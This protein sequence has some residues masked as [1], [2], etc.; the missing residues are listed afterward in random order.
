MPY[1]YHG[2]ILHV[3]LDN[4]SFSVETPPETFYRKYMGGSAFGAYYLLKNTPTNIDPYS[5]E[6]TLVLSVG[7]VTGA[8]ISG[9]S[10][11]TATAKSP[12]TGGIGDSQSGGFFPVELKFAGFDAIVIHGQSPTPVYLWINEGHAELR[13]AEHLW[14]QTTGEVEDIIKKELEDNKVQI[15]QTGIAG[16]NGVRFAAL[17]SMENRANGRTGMGAVMGSKKL[18]AVVVRGTKR[19][20]LANPKDLKNLA[21]LGAKEFPNSDVY[22]MGLLGT[23]EV[24]GYQ[25]SAGGLPTRNWTSGSFDGW[26]SITGEAMSETILKKRD[27]CYAC[28]VRCKRV[29]EVQEGPYKV[30]PRYGGPEYETLST[31]GSYCEIDDLEAIAYANQLCNMYGM[32]TISCGATIAWAMDAFESGLLTLEDTGGIELRFGNAAVMTKMVEAIARRDGIGNL[33]AEGS[34]LAAEKIGR[35]AKDIVVAVKNLEVPAHMPEVKHSLG[36]IYAVNPFGADHQ[37]SE[38]DPS[39][40]SYPERMAQLGLTNAKD[41]QGF[42]NETVRFAA[43]TQYFYSALDSLS[44]CQFVFGPSWHLFSPQQLLEMLQLVTGWDVDM[45]ELLRVGERRLNLLRAF[46]AREGFNS[47]DDILPP[48]MFQPLRGGSSDGIALDENEVKSAI[49]NYYQLVGWDSET[50]NPT[51]EKLSELGL[52]W[53]EI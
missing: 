31:F 36:V 21:R 7:V 14:G 22:H 51:P 37:S 34:A 46:N 2:K 48:K 32:D 5:P 53:V 33:L 8:P 41:A 45:D 47:Q 27:T 10:R 6:N 15:L 11:L 52:D 3:H 40:A 30:K 38:H 28:V 43:I 42:N 26:K 9:Q 18:K 24:I 23:A 12:L 44:V 17:I 49:I 16:E 4:S 35:G 29:V 19:P 50:G 13:P 39:Y 25:N 1:G 20:S